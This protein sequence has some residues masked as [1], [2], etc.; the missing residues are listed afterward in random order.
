MVLSIIA[1]SGLTIAPSAKAAASTGDLIKMSG[2]TSV[3]YLGADGKRYVFPNS[4]TYFSWYTDFSGVVTIP[5]A[6][7]QSYPLG[8]NVTMRPGTKLVKI[9]TDPKVY[10][11]EPNGVLRGIQTEAQAASLF[12]TSWNKRV[13]DVPD[14]FF[15]NYTTGTALATGATPAGSIVK[16][17]GSASVYY[18]DGTNYRTIADE[19]AFNAN[20]FQWA[21]V[22]TI[23]NTIAA[24][25]TTVSTAEFVN[26]SQGGSTGTVITGSGLMV[27]LSASTP[28]AI[29]VPENGAR[30]PM[31]KVNLTAANDGAVTVNSI[32]VKRIGLSEYGFID[33]VWA[34]KDSVIVAP[35]KTMNSNDESIL[36]F[37]PA[38]TVNAGQTV[39][40]DLIVSFKDS[41]TVTGNIGLSIATA[42]AVSATSASVT[43]SFPVNGNLMSPTAYSVVT[44]AITDPSTST[45]TVKVG[46]EKVELGKF[47]LGFNGTAKDVTLKS[48]MFKN[49]GVE[50]LST[51]AMNLYLEN[52][53]NKVS[54]NTVVDGRFVTFY[55]PSTGLDLLKDDSSKIFYIKGDVIA[56]ENTTNPAFRFLLNKSTD[57]VGYE[58]ATGFGANV[59]NATSG[60][61]AADSFAISD[62]NIDA[63][64]ISVSKKATS[65]SDTTII[66]GSDNLMLLANVR[67]D[68]V[69]TADGLNIKYTGVS[70]TAN[71]DQFENVRVYLNGILLD[72]FDPAATSTG[73]LSHEVDST[74]NLN[75]GD[76][77]I[78]V[79]AKAKTTA[80]SSAIK[81]VLD[82]TIFTS[83]NPEY[84]VSGNAVSGSISG[85]AA[86]GIFTVS[87][88]ALTTVR[89]DGYSSG[90]VVVAGSSDVSLGKFTLKATN[91]DVKVTS[92]SLGTNASTSPENSGNISDMKIFVDGVQVGSTVDFGSTGS[93]F[94]SLNFTI[95]KDST[96]AVELKG[97]FDS[98]A[99]GGF[100]TL[101]TVNAQ[102]SRGTAISSGNTASTSVF[103]LA[104]SGSLNVEVSG[105]TPAAA[106]LATKSAE[107]EVAQ[108]KFTAVNDSADLSEINVYNSASST[109]T[110]T[111]DS[112]IASIK[113]YDGATLI[114]SFVPVN[115]IGKFTIA[116][117]KIKVNAN[118][119]KTLSIKVA[120]NNIDND[121]N[122]TNK[123]LKITLSTVKAKSSSGSEYTSAST[124]VSAN[125]FRI[126]KTIPTVALSALPATLLTA[127][128]AVISKFTVTADSN[129]DVTLKKIVLTATTS[130]ATLTGMA[131]GNA[132]RIN[133]SMK[134]LASSTFVSA[135]GLLTLDF[136]DSVV[137]VIS[138]GTSK[139]FEVY[140]TV[141]GTLDTGSSV[142]TKITAPAN[143]TAATSF[144]WSDGA[145]VTTPTYSNGY[146]VPGLTTMTQAMSK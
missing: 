38:L 125:Q 43:G 32:T 25:G 78:K 115:G 59:Y 47:T 106:I 11:V 138:A 77:E 36:T 20:R 73:T 135:T 6:E 61:T 112:R 133:G 108:F 57:L 42:A 82:S 87:G 140:G 93:T 131:A 8:G 86:G 30:V 100:E 99:L 122:A 89:S 3:Y 35:K 50:D 137:E 123:D 132:V 114:D 129:G 128:D 22:I 39:S 19:N 54:V 98:A 102:D 67:A 91:G 92:I 120:L 141:G 16:N 117:G 101:M 80:T 65:P 1:M 48:V 2:N 69:I 28:A 10:V 26:V 40:L 18:Y 109:A 143:F 118:E 41:A 124:Y 14:A 139:T 84:V 33:K 104:A 127:G 105:N 7:L 23:S 130:G 44:L 119:S 79:W 113:L 46:D 103:A 27:S 58:K 121:A 142:T 56:K 64:A 4:T 81:F 97:T 5:A 45:T 83:Q 95:A 90:K 21:N 9:T 63:G 136:A 85:T 55:F 53:G 31:A 107:Q 49:N 24:G 15:T 145:S 126:R 12:G 146:E 144:E 66:K 96:K 94:S 13:V 34:E 52:A 51:A 70:A 88:T 116:S 134:A 72:S 29:S 110:S 111:A 62:V 76:N 17:A 68:E 37:S 74:L 75:K 71:T 60:G